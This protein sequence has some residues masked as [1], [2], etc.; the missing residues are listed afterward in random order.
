MVS[1][2]LPGFRTGLAI[3]DVDEMP[4]WNRGGGFEALP[5]EAL[6]AE[7]D[8]PWIG[9][10]RIQESISI[11]TNDQNVARYV[12]QDLL[13]RAADNASFQPR[14]CDGPHDHDVGAVS[15]GECRQYLARTTG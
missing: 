8:W 12:V 4:R 14:S 10:T 2:A 9:V 3:A 6:A 1:D 11:A 5:R 7:Q 13:G 15:A